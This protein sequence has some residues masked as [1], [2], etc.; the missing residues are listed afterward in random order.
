MRFLIR[1]RIE[2]MSLR[3]FHLVFVGLAL[4]LLWGL[5]AACFYFYKNQGEEKAYLI[6]GITGGVL[7]LALFIYGI[8]FCIKMRRLNQS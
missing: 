7:G 1:L 8:T 6:A 5:A 2:S 3:W 4:L